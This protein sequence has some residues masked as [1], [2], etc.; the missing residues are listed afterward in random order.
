MSRGMVSSCLLVLVLVCV[1]VSAHRQDSVELVRPVPVPVI[2]Y[3][4][5]SPRAC[6]IGPPV[7]VTDRAYYLP[8]GAAE[9]FPRANGAIKVPVGVRVVFCLSRDL[10]GVWYPHSYGC[11]GT[12]LI[13]QWCRWCKC[14][15]ATCLE[16][17]CPECDCLE[18]DPDATDV[19][20]CPWVTI[21]RDGAKDVRKGPSIGRA[22]VG[23]PV[24]FRRPG[25][26]YM[27]GIIH[28]V[29]KPWYIRPLEP[30]RERILG[31][32]DGDSASVDI[33]PPI[34]AAEDK[35]IV[36]V[37]VH[38]VDL[39]ILEVEPEEQTPDDPDVAHIKPMPKDI[40][41]NQPSELSADLNL[42][43][44]VNFADFAIMAQQWGKEYEM[45]FSDDE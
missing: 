30:W 37:R 34:P 2:K 9:N 25:I 26:Y 6:L 41:P 42:D 38:V 12:S 15:D 17:K 44:V 28:T 43:E 20:R 45:P 18:C 23:V 13:L 4:M 36:Y 21:G 40:D 11:L 39:P 1:A 3:A 8:T 14:V 24:C 10:E 32:T 19:R 31:D 33:L 27:R 5:A 7:W 16:Y 35:D 22:K 29:A